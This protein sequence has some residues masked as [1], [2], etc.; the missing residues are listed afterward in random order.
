M[1]MFILHCCDHQLPLRSELGNDHWPVFDPKVNV[2]I[3]SLMVLVSDYVCAS[4]RV[5]ESMFC[6]NRLFKEQHMRL[7]DL[8]LDSS[9]LSYY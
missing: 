2:G 7:T 9:T 3:R 1:C 5:S 8:G 6:K 4:Q